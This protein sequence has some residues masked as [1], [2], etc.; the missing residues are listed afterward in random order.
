ML[1]GICNSP[2]TFHRLRERVLRSIIGLGVIVY[3]ADV[4]IY[5]K[6]HKQLIKIISKV[7]K[8]LAMSGI[9][10]KDFKCFFSLNTSTTSF[11]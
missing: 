9:E 6:T 5:A 2:A 3:I 4:L 10:C 7:L 8:L 1:F 11:A